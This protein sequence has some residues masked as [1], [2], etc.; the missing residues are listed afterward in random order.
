MDKLFAK[1]IDGEVTGYNTNGWGQTYVSMVFTDDKDQ[2]I[3]KKY[4]K[5][6]SDMTWNEL[7]EL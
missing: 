7:F 1:V 3:T 2:C 6:S 4:T 5:Y